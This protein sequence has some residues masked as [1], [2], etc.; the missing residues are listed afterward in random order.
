MT[1]YTG[2]NR[3]RIHHVDWHVNWQLR[4]AT[5]LLCQH[6]SEEL[7][8]L[9]TN[10]LPTVQ[11]RVHQSALQIISLIFRQP[12]LRRRVYRVEKLIKDTHD[13]DPSYK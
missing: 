5:F 10:G 8:K 9:S 1:P 11:N 6:L 13:V 12:L 3:T 7:L 2:K 4:T